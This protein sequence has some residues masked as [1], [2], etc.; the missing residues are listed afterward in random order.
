ML[1]RAAFT[2]LGQFIQNVENHSRQITVDNETVEI[3]QNQALPKLSD[4]KQKLDEVTKQQMKNLFKQEEEI[5]NM[6]F[7]LEQFIQKLK[8]KHSELSAQRQIY[9]NPSNSPE[10]EI[11]EQEIIG[12]LKNELNLQFMGCLAH[13]P[14]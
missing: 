1:K 2:Y 8:S 9:A 6:K 13:C 11:Q 7:F 3:R 12:N 5:N 4:I 14:L 10:L